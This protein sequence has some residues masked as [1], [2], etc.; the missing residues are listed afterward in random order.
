M[1]LRAGRKVVV[2]DAGSIGAGEPGRTT[3]H[4][5]SA[6]DDRVSRL[7]QHHGE[8]AAQLAVESHAAAIRCI[9]RIVAEEEIDCQFERLDGYLFSPGNGISTVLTDEHEALVRA[10]GTG[11][12]W[13]ARAPLP[14]YET[15]PCLRFPDQAAFHPLLYL[16][17][18]ARAVLDLGG[19]ILTDARMGPDLDEGPPVRIAAASGHTVVADALVVATNAPAIDFSELSSRQTA[20]RTY[21]IAATVPRG[22]ITRA[23][24]WDTD[25]PYHY[26]RVHTDRERHEDVLIVGGEDHRTGHDAAVEDRYAALEAWARARFN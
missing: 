5:S 8:E 13:M 12:S 23:L 15:G 4:L 9:E 20:M 6:I 14:A 10:G 24:Y 17:G 18:L 7:A 16:N 3:A 26:A 21:A 11:V 25:T 1:L 22:S 19:R 2:L